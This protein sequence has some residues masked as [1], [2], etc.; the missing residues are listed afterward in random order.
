MKWNGE[1]K[2]F[3]AAGAALA[4]LASLGA[5]YRPQARS[6]Y[7]TFNEKV[8]WFLEWPLFTVGN[9]PVTLLFLI[10]C[11]IFLAALSLLGRLVQK[12][13][14]DR[15]L[16]KTSID[17]GRQYA[18]ARACRY[19]VVLL[20]LTIGLDTTGINLRSMVLLGGA[21]GVGIGFGL[22]N[23]VANFVAGVVI[24]WEGPVKV[25]DLID[26]GSTTGEVVRIGARGTWVRTFDNEVII[27]PNS[28]FVNN[29]VTNW[30]AND[31]TVR[32]SVPVGV[33]YDADFHQVSH[34]LEEIA[35]LN[36]EVLVTPAPAVLVTGFG[37]NAVNLVLRATASNAER[38]GTVKSDLMLEILRVF[39]E[40]KIEMPGPQR[41]LHIRSVDA[42]FVIS[43][44]AASGGTDVRR[45]T[46][47]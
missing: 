18:I 14:S 6:L 34:L 16:S 9:V 17:R 11:G 45:E 44:P 21:L 43:G 33:S 2:T 32:L 24:L 30:T 42:P 38:A 8:K 31:R 36:P 22:Q 40:Q 10:K 3:V 5:W 46:A 29:R 37:D 25:G 27:V 23:I 15:V 35:R 47:A 4:L 1:Q 12:F 39:R 41:D 19:I 13:M 28:D 20:G 7:D 26:V